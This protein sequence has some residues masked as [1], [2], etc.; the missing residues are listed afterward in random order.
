MQKKT[1]LSLTNHYPLVIGGVF[2]VFSGGPEWRKR[3][4]E[5]L[6]A[7][8]KWPYELKLMPPIGLAKLMEFSPSLHPTNPTRTLFFVSLIVWFVF[9]GKKNWMPRKVVWRNGLS[10]LIF[11]LCKIHVDSISGDL[12]Q[13][14]TLF[15]AAEVPRGVEPE[16]AEAEVQEAGHE[17]DIS[18]SVSNKHQDSD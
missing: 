14:S 3:H 2:S 12:W 4:Q 8:G 13:P 15:D 1:H 17:M 7:C 6:E 16:E 10:R 11:W 9:W 5:M 18:V